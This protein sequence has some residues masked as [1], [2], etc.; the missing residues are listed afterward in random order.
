VSAHLIDRDRELVRLVARHRVLTTD[1]LTGLAFSNLTTA[2][3][4]PRATAPRDR[5]RPL[6]TSR[7][8]LSISAEVAVDGLPAPRVSGEIKPTGSESELQTDEAADKRTAHKP[9]RGTKQATAQE[10]PSVWA[11]QL[12]A[13][14]PPL[15]RSEAINVARIAA[16]LDM[17]TNADGD[18]H[19]R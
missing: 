18:T 9:R 3:R 10:D 1:Q 19:E 16:R 12:A 14:L 17:C 13:A 7:V 8:S 4:P 15:S 11:A 5:P 6:T 2:R